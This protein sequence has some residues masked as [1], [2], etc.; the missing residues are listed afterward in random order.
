MRTRFVYNNLHAVSEN[1]QSMKK[2]LITLLCVLSVFSAQG[3]DAG[4][5][6]ISELEGKWQ[7]VYRG[8]YGYQFNFSKNYRAVCIIFLSTS[9]VIFRGV[10]TIEDRNTIRINISEM[11]K[12]DGTSNIDL[13]SRFVKTSS[14]YFIFGVGLG[15]RQ[16]SRTLQM[17]PKKVII[18]GN[19]SDGYFEPEF[20]LN[21]I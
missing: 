8:N 19:S 14:T 3:L 16:G 10:Y 4:N 21:R 5:L 17:A 9:T 7:L 13:R 18:D 15:G 20:T 2:A 1:V 11:K 12:Q 6:K